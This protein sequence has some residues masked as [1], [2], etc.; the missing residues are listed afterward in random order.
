M[1]TNKNAKK[2][3][4]A[5]HKAVRIILAPILVPYIKLKYRL[6]VNNSLLPG[7][8]Q[9]LV[10]FNH[11]TSFDQ[12]FINMT[13]PGAIYFMASE[14]I[15][16]NGIISRIIKYLA[17]PIPIKKQ[18]TDVRAVLNC[19]RV[20]K[21]GG[22]IAI[23]PEGNR[24][25]S[26][27]TGYIN[28]SIAQLIKKLELP[29]VFVRLE[30]G[31][32]KEPRWGRGVRRGKMTS[33]VTRVFSPEEFKEKSYAEIL[34]IVEKELYVDENLNTGVYPARKGAEYL[35]RMLYTCP[36]HGFTELYSKGN[37]V[38][39]KLCKR[40]VTYTADKRFV[41]LGFDFPYKTPGEW[42]LR[43]EEFINTINS[44]TPS[45]GPLYSDVCKFK[46]VIAYKNK[47][48]IGARA[49][50]YLYLDRVEIQLNGVSYSFGFD[51]AACLTVLG[52][53]KLNIYF[54]GEI[55]QLKGNKRFCA[56]KYVNL[57]YRYKNLTGGD[58]NGK[59]LGL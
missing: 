4:R 12:F 17:A 59:F 43:Q 22:T 14:D 39:C 57:Y 32:G 6:K 33:T 24:T 21:E 8:G 29:V 28:P 1:A 42:Y 15:F 26:G 25:Y 54:D 47:Q 58:I 19:M 2:W 38:E 34:N 7:R 16:S 23:A 30:G 10:L 51:K 40:K 48:L 49:A 52:R 18:T 53:N 13:V 56:L 45:C 50:V 36:Y 37:T 46:R 44:L 27:K 20:A 55:Y 35:E 41:G 11:Q 9:Y 3:C 5:R 31:Y